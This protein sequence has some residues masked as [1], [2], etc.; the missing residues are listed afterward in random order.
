MAKREQ[1]FETCV[2]CGRLTDVRRDTPVQER[3][4]YEEGS[5]QLCARCYSELVDPAR[6]REK[7]DLVWLEAALHGRFPQ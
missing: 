7:E 4:G 1:D 5:G 3:I 6:K 2:I